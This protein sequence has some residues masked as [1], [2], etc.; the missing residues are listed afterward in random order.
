MLAKEGIVL[1]EKDE[2]S[3]ALGMKLRR[4]DSIVIQRAFELTLMNGTEAMSI[5]TVG[6]PVS[7]VLIENG[8]VL[9]EMDVVSPALDHACYTG[10]TNPCNT[11]CTGCS[12]GICGSPL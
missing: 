9:G 3:P 7:D 6:K 2:V 4:E 8:I 10:D 11:R 1:N 12:G 5:R